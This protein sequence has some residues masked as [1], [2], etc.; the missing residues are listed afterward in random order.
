MTSTLEPP[1]TRDDEPA[2]TLEADFYSFQELLTGPEQRAL[3]QVRQFLDTDVRPRADQFWERGESPRHLVPRLA[4][5]GLFGD[6]FD[7]TRLFEN[8][9]VYRGWV[10][11]NEAIQRTS[12]PRWRRRT[13]PRGCA[14]PSRCAE[15]SSVATA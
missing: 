8:S 10:A 7:E 13:S 5:L 9:C 2:E 4:D 15:R 12:T 11:M 1:F 3:R 6:A 14:R